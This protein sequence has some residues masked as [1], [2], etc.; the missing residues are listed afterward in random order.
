MLVLMA[1]AAVACSKERMISEPVRGEGAL[2]ISLDGPQGKSGMTEGTS[3]V[4]KGPSALTLD[5]PAVD[6]FWVEIYNSK[7][8]RFFSRQYVN[9]KERPIGLN[10]GQFRMIAF[11]GDTLGAGFGK[12]YYVADTTFNIHGFKASGGQPESLHATARLGNVGLRVNFGENLQ[13]YYSNYYAVVRHETLTKKSVKFQKNETRN[14]YIPGGGIYLEVFAQLGG[15]GM[16]DGGVKDSLVY[17]RSEAKQYSPGDFITFNVDCPERQGNMDLQILLD[18]S[19]P[20]TSQLVSI[21]PTTPPFISYRGTEASTFTQSFSIGAGASANDAT[22]SFGSASGIREATLQIINGYLTGTAGLPAS[23]DLIDTPAADKTA[24]NAAGISWN[25]DYDAS[26]GYINVGGTLPALSIHSEYST[27][28]PDVAA[29]T[30]TVKDAYGKTATSTLN[31]RGEPIKGTVYAENTDIWGW[32]IASP[33]AVLLGVENIPAEAD[34]RLLYSVDGNTWMQAAKKSVSGNTVYFNDAT[35]LA[36]DTQYRFRVMAGGNA[37]N[38]TGD[39]MFTTES[40][41]QLANNGFEEISEQAT[42]VPTAT[43]LGYV[44]SKFT[45]TWWQ[46]YQEGGQPKIWAVN[47]LVSIRESATAAY[48]D[49]KSYPT[50]AVFTSGAYSGNSIQVATIGEASAASEILYGTYHAGEL[51]IGKANNMVYSSWEKT[52]EGTALTSRPYAVAFKCKFNCNDSKPYYVH[53]EILD[54]DGNKIG[55]GTKND[56][57]SSINDWTTVS[58]PITYSITNRKAATIKLSFMSSKDG[59]DNNHR[60][61]TVTTLSG[62]HKLHAGNILSLDN[63][64]LI[65]SE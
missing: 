12:A 61:V 54:A 3:G 14:G 15:K 28:N 31:L 55:E 30:L 44:L 50:V 59:S 52:A 19:A 21:P 32:K 33:R 8:I 29:F 37:D 38:V 23:V 53:T 41:V 35:G 16:Q 36:P 58:V 42:E 39:S 5:L 7:S 2:L 34:L 20:V 4:T 65:Y 6:S 56:Q 17:Y 1:L 49:Y 48:Q 43:I 64:E 26:Y 24:L 11:S 25:A 62:E 63:I 10:I 45:I 40:N 9:V 18:D 46:L 51:Y 60:T 47:S 27:A 22:M 57:K 13:T